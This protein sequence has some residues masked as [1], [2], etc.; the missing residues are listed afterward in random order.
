MT[1]NQ[2]ST[3]H[4]YISCHIIFDENKFPF[5]NHV[6]HPSTLKS[7]IYTIFFNQI[8][9]W[10][11]THGHLHPYP[12][13]FYQLIQI[14]PNHITLIIIPSH[15]FPPTRPSKLAFHLTF[16]PLTHKNLHTTNSNFSFLLHLYLDLQHKFFHYSTNSNT[17]N[18]TNFITALIPTHPSIATFTTSYWS[19][20]PLLIPWS[21]FSF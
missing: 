19:P 7:N 10:S 18:F 1:P 4:Q 13:T 16:Q 21:V 8:S 15:P 5:K 3:S 20:L 17:S 12:P 9:F 2:T 11:L 14:K 6:S